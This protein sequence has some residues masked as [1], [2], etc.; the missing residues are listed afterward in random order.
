M[1]AWY[2]QLVLEF[3]RAQSLTCLA[4]T[5]HT[6]TS[7][8]AKGE[9]ALRSLRRSEGLAID[10]SKA[11]RELLETVGNV[12]VVFESS[13]KLDELTEAIYRHPVMCI[14]RN[15]WDDVSEVEEAISIYKMQS[16]VASHFVDT[17]VTV[18]IDRLAEFLK[19][20]LIKSR[21]FC[22]PRECC[23]LVA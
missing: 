12:Q 2:G 14:D 20:E 5:V 11:R 8:P 16:E 6:L 13:S 9:E 7:D 17:S 18:R 23:E 1:K 21:Y 4:D 19:Q 22:L 15:A 3:Y 10:V